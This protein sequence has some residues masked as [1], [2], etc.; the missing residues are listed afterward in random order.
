M[1]TELI[2]LAP[3]ARPLL[4]SELFELAEPYLSGQILAPNQNGPK[5]F[6]HD[7]ICPDHLIINPDTG[8]LVGVID[9][10]DAMVGDI[11]LDFVG[12]IGLGGYSFIKQV[13][14]N[15]DLDLGEDFQV[16]LEWLARNLTL[17]WLAKEG[18]KEAGDIDKH[19]AWVKHAF[20][21]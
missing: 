20:N 21:Y 14:D 8:R 18:V 10:T 3:Q 2:D 17:R 19:L 16:Q 6:I 9:F 7:D 1:R 13:T 5:R 15:Y 12:L 4:P 11:V